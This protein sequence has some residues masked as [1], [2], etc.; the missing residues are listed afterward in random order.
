MPAQ[1]PPAPD[2]LQESGERLWAAVMGDFVLAAHERAVLLEAC[3][4]ADSLDALQA[5]VD[6]AGVMCQSTQGGPRVHPALVELRQQRLVLARLVAALR[7]PLEDDDV[8]PSRH[9]PV[10]AASIACPAHH[11]TPAAGGSGPIA[12]GAGAP[13]TRAPPPM[14]PGPRPRSSRMRSAVRWPSTATT[15]STRCALDVGCAGADRGHRGSR[16]MSRSRSPITWRPPGSPVAGIRHSLIAGPIP[17]C[18]SPWA[19]G[20]VDLHRAPVGALGARRGPV[21]PVPAWLAWGSAVVI[22]RFRLPLQRGSRI[23]AFSS[24]MVPIGRG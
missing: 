22:R 6:G 8:R 11:E 16:P 19:G 4:T 9:G 23:L 2:G 13:C 15:R 3:R 20:W 7:I 1:P 24:M 14:R 12:R 10:C 21:A 5:E 17:G 18:A